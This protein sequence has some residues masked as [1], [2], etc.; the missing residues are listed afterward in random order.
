[1]ELVVGRVAK[2]HGVTGEVVGGS[3]CHPCGHI[4]LLVNGEV[5]YVK[6]MDLRVEKRPPLPRPEPTGLP[7][8]GSSRG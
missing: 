7:S 1:M 6:G 2:A 8:R 5:L 3:D 4:A